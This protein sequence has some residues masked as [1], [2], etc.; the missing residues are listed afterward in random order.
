MI[1]KVGQGED[2]FEIVNCASNFVWDEEG[3]EI[4]VKYG[5]QSSD[6]LFK[7]ERQGGNNTFW[8]KTSAKGKEAVA[9]E[10]VLRYKSFDPNVT[11]QLFYIVPVNNCTALN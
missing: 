8:F 3:K 5:K 9:L 10:G 7:V 11:N 2:E 4:R 6:Q 1:E